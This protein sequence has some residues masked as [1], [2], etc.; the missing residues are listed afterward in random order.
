MIKYDGPYKK[1]NDQNKD[2][3]ADFKGK[4]KTGYDVADSWGSKEYLLK[5]RIMPKNTG[6]G[7][8]LY[9][10]GFFMLAWP[11]ELCV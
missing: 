10:L 11:Y 4:M 8:R 1:V 5:R 2:C 9:M 7:N 3:I 6:I